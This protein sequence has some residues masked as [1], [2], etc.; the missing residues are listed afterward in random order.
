[1]NKFIYIVITIVL[2]L[3]HLALANKSPLLSKKGNLEEFVEVRFD[4]NML[5][6][7]TK[8]SGIRYLLLNDSKDDPEKTN[9]NQV[10]KIPIGQ[11]CVFATKGSSVTLEP[12]TNKRGFK[13]TKK[14]DHR[15][16]GKGV[17]KTSFDLLIDDRGQLSYGNV[18]ES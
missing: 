7:T 3:G 18:V 16:R 4:D 17:E 6:V 8:A 10:I 11:T 9:Y 1:M 5:I 15:S 12:L 2:A 13:I 14:V